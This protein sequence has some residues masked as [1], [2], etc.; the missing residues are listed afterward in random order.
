MPGFAITGYGGID[1]AA[2]RPGFRKS[3]QYNLIDNLTWVRNTHSIKIGTDI[4][5]FSETDENC[6][7]CRSYFTFTG[8]YTEQWVR[9]LHASASILRVS[10]HLPATKAGSGASGRSISTFRTTG[11]RLPA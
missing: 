8:S 7:Y 3:N 1:P 11:K 5:W 2:F 4:R 9:G 10:G 6:A